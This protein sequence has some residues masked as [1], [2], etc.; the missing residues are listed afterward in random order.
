[1]TVNCLRFVSKRKTVRVRAAPVCGHHHRSA[2]ARNSE[3][4]LTHKPDLALHRVVEILLS[5]A[6]GGDPLP[7]L[8]NEPPARSVLRGAPPPPPPPNP[9]DTQPPTPAK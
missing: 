4:K 2:T 6:G 5:L 3:H 1:M 8:N 7:T 9:L